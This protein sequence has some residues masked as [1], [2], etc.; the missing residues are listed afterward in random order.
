M[1]QKFAD[2]EVVSFAMGQRNPVV[3]RGLCVK[4]D[5]LHVVYSARRGV[6]GAVHR[7]PSALSGQTGLA[8][9]LVVLPPSQSRRRCIDPTR[10]AVRRRCS[11]AGCP[12]P[13]VRPGARTPASC[14]SS[15]TPGTPRP[16]TA[17]HRGCRR[18][19]VPRTRPTYSISEGTMK[20]VFGQ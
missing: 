17:G 19:P 6:G 18:R 14:S 7:A 12:A 15:D 8:Q 16:A 5:R 2:S 9:S 13:S 20:G 4:S 3:T 11:R 1:Q 10:V